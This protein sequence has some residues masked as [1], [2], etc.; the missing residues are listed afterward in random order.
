LGAEKG[1]GLIGCDFTGT[2]AFFI[3]DDLLGDNFLPPYT[4]QIH[5]EPSRFFL[6]LSDGRSRSFGDPINLEK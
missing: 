4:S 6:D 5:Y 2:N 1:Y 3:R